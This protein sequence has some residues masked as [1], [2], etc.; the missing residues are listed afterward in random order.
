MSLLCLP[1]T[2]ECRAAESSN[3]GYVFPVS[4]VTGCHFEVKGRGWDHNT[5]MSRVFFSVLVKK[6]DRKSIFKMTCFV[7]SGISNL[8]SFNQYHLYYDAVLMILILCVFV[9]IFIIIDRVAG[10]IIRFVASMCACV[11]PFVCGHSPV[12]TV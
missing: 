7:S 6:L 2:R 12:R 1:L 5:G 9:F 8:N 3:L 11:R 10:E 4:N